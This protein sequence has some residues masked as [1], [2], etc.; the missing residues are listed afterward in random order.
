M[1]FM[2]DLDFSGLP[3]ELDP[4]FCQAVH[5]FLNDPRMVGP[6]ECEA[7]TRAHLAMITV[8]AV[9]AA[10]M[11]TLLS[12]DRGLTWYGHQQF[13]KQPNGNVLCPTLETVVHRVSNQLL[14]QWRP[15]ENGSE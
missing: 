8:P 3:E 2:M 6:I 4:L 10:V 14:D 13:Q 9:R 5:R 12:S 7:N 15:E 1:G 11:D